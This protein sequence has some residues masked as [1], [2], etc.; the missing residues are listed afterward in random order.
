MKQT[1]YT[2]V[3]IPQHTTS[4]HLEEFCCKTLP[5]QWENSE[6]ANI[7]EENSIPYEIIDFAKLSEKY[8]AFTSALNI[9]ELSNLEIYKL[10]TNSFD[11]DLTQKLK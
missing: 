8:S 5:Y 9:D 2:N 7:Y 4:F 3:Y 10:L 1:R 6:D 11:D